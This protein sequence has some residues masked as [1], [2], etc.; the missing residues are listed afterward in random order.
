MLRCRQSLQCGSR[1]LLLRFREQSGEI[2]C[3]LR[4]AD[5]R[6]PREVFG[7]DLRTFV[8]RP[9]TLDELTLRVDEP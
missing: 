5:G 7:D 9:P 3:Q 2:D 4:V 8:I 6:L 1:S